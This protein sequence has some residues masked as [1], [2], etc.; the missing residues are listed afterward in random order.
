MSH[1]HQQLQSIYPHVPLPTRII[2][3][4]HTMQPAIRVS[5]YLRH[6]DALQQRMARLEKEQLELKNIH[7]HI[8]AHAQKNC[9]HTDI[10]YEDNG[11]CHNFRWD[12]YCKLCNAIV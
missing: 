8:I 7:T 10:R 3:C 6:A 5:L 2:S 12:K 4:I 9:P 11:D 1:P